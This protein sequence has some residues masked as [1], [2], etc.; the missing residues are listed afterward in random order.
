M[1][2]GESDGQI[3]KAVKGGRCQD[4]APLL[5]IEQGSTRGTAASS[6]LPYLSLNRPHI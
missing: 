5:R 3:L 2:V 6:T 4:S 1:N